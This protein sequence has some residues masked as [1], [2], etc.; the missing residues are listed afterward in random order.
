MQAFLR[1]R[2][3][4]WE[5]ANISQINSKF[6]NQEQH[7]IDFKNSLSRWPSFVKE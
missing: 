3:K 1:S 2:L 5:E 7:V 6:D 4:T